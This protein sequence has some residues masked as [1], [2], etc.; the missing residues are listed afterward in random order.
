MSGNLTPHRKIW[1]PLNISGTIRDRKL[2]FYSHIDDI[3]FLRVKIFSKGASEGCSAHSV[4]L[5]PPYI[6]ETIR[7]RKLKFYT[8]LD[9]VRYT[10]D[11]K[12]FS[13]RGGTPLSVNLGHICTIKRQV[14]SG[15]SS[16]LSM[17]LVVDQ[18]APPTPIA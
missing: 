14:T 2:K 6:S 1:N 9:R 16:V 4:N 7:G 15:L 10:S 17:C 8:H 5:G 13:A 12:M 18:S 11:M 3:L